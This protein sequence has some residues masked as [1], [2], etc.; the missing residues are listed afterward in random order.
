[1]VDVNAPDALDPNASSSDFYSKLLSKVAAPKTKSQPAPAA[2]EAAFN[3]KKTLP[4]SRELFAPANDRMASSATPGKSEAPHAGHVDGEAAPGD[5]YAK[6]LAKVKPPQGDAPSAQS[7]QPKQT[8]ERKTLP[9]PSWGALAPEKPP[10]AAL[11]AP[12][13]F[14]P[15]ATQLGL[16]EIEVHVD[17]PVDIAAPE[18][19]PKV[20]PNAEPNARL[21]P[22]PPK[23]SE[24]PLAASIQLPPMSSTAGDARPPAGIT[25]GASAAS[26]S[27]ATSANTTLATNPSSTAPS[28]GAAAASSPDPTL[29]PSVKSMAAAQPAASDLGP[30]ARRTQP[31]R[32]AG[33]IITVIGVG[34]LG[35]GGGV[36]ATIYALKPSLRA[37][38][39]APAVSP[40]TAAAPAS[41]AAA[42]P[43]QPAV[44]PAAP[45]AQSQSAAADSELP[46]PSNETSEKAA[47]PKSAHNAA[48]GARAPTQPAAAAPR[49]DAV[50]P[51][52]ES[53]VPGWLDAKSAAKTSNTKTVLPPAPT[54]APASKGSGSGPFP[55]EVAMAML[56]VAAS[57]APACKK[58]GGPTGAGKAIVT[59]DT[60]GQVVI[61]NI[62]GEGFAG[63]PTGQCV[64][65]LFRRVRVPP[66]AG[67]RAT[68]T[69]VFNIP[70]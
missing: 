64:A 54:P 57:Q 11:S 69:K 44:A 30:Y 15:R 9:P 7:T 38:E 13:P 51:S 45:P 63:S 34:L 58:P 40:P 53:N 22:V 56:G 17:V 33:M 10:T 66:F 42:Q 31:R 70:P 60:D 4:P 52:T 55:K 43:Q 49:K 24:P 19:S 32:F 28:Q 1:V 48:V 41:V 20:P 68:A 14:N 6:I 39:E 50:K 21:V 12:A 67:D 16:G 26:S 29:E 36:A 8:S 47:A 3:P 65:A 18:T 23:R 5:F 62:V 59:F 61:T 37:T 25:L 27:A 2:N 35:V 46:K